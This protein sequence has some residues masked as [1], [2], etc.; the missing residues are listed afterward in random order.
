MRPWGLV[1]RRADDHGSVLHFERVG[2]GTTQPPV[3]PRRQVATGSPPDR[4]EQ[5]VDRGVVPRV[6]GEVRTQAREEILLADERG[7]LLQDGLSLGVSDHV[8]AG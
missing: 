7:E 3:R 4:V 2:P 5:V 1:V 6:G 8:E